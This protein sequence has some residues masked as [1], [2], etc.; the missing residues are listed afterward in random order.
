MLC[1]F[2]HL[3]NVVVL[4]SVG[5]PKFP[6]SIIWILLSLSGARSL[7]SCLGGGDVDG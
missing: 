6:I 2:S 3:K 1:L 4:P 7:A 5:M